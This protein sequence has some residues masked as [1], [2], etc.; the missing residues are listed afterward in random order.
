MQSSHLYLG[1]LSYFMIYL[2]CSLRGKQA[3]PV[4]AELVGDVE[5]VL[6][7]C[8]AARSNSKAVRAFQFLIY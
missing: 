5:S 7:V 1:F 2:L 8:D 3:Y 6:A 4:P